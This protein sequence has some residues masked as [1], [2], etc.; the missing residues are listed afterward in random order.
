MIYYSSVEYNEET[1]SG[2]EYKSW[3]QIRTAQVSRW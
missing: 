2:A 1:C 3:V